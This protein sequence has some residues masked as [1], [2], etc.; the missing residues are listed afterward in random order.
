[1]RGRMTRRRFDAAAAASPFLL[2]G[3]NPAADTMGP[4]NTVVLWY[5][6]RSIDDD[7]FREFEQQHDGITVDNQ[8]VGGDYAGKFNTMLAGKA[9]VP[10]VVALNEDVSRYFPDQAQ[11]EDLAA[12]GADE[13]AGEYLPWKYALGKTPEGKQ[14]AFPMDSGP[15][16]LF[17]RADLFE[18]AGLPTDPDEVAALMPTWEAYFEQGVKLHDAV[19]STVLHTSVSNMFLQMLAQMEIRFVNRENE[20]VGDQ[21]HIRAAWDLCIDAHDK[22][23]FANVYDWTPDWSAACSNGGFATFV[24]AVWMKQ[25]IIEAAPN[26]AGLWRVT[27]APGGPGNQGGSFLAVTKYANDK[28]LGFELI[29]YLQSPENQVRQYRSLNLFP[30]ALES[31]DDPVMQEPEE[32]FGG[33]ATAAVFADVARTLK[34][35]YFE[36]QWPIV[37]TQMNNALITATVGGGDRAHA[38][39]DAQALVRKELRHKAPTVTFPES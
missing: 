9:Y 26:T 10:D 33:Q 19:P 27:K 8:K 31:L 38:W 25:P 23:L 6:N 28:Q 11:F 37:L 36:P 14:M 16:A 2:A 4:D 1:M 24:G 3:C 35:F 7:L 15:T 30:A 39:D 18:Q 13:V 32:F 5:W 34:P 17:Y 22:G 20:Y 29:T 21:E 12:L